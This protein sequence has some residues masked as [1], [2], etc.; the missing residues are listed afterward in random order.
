MNEQD[1]FWLGVDAKLDTSPLLRTLFIF[2]GISV[3]PVI[4]FGIKYWTLI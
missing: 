3:I 4:A 2:G 1:K